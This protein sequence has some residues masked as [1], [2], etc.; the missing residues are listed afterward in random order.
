MEIESPS[1]NPLTVTVMTELPRLLM[2]HLRSALLLCTLFAKFFKNVLKKLLIQA[3]PSYNLTV[4][5]L[6]SV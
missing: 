6:N 1:S 2:R 3:G 4:Q 5:A